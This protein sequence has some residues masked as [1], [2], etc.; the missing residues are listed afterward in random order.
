MVSVRRNGGR[1]ARRKDGRDDGGYTRLFGDAKLGALISRTHGACISSGIML[2]K[3]ILEHA[4]SNAFLIEDL[5]EFLRP[6]LLCEGVFLAS[7]RAIK[8]SKI[9]DSPKS[10]PDFVIFERRGLRQHCYVVE[11]KDGDAFDTKKSSG[12]RG[13]IHGFVNRLA[14]HVRYTVSVHFCCFNQDDKDAIVNGLKRRITHEEAMTG[15]EFCAL[16]GIDYEDFVQRRR[17]NQS[18][19][20]QDFIQCLLDIPSVR[21]EIEA[22]LER[23]AAGYLAPERLAGAAAEP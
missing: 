23:E 8:R 20:F 22:G 18:E 17:E 19:R 3:S 21:A 11:L 12:E 13:T 2:E 1:L 9:I 15:K 16:L 6:D 14:P 5:D 10:E 7:K 4:K